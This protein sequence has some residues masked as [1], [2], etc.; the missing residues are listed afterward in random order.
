MGS[1]Q[2]TSKEP[3]DNVLHFFFNNDISLFCKVDIRCIYLF[4]QNH[5]TVYMQAK[6]IYVPAAVYYSVNN[7]NDVCLDLLLQVLFQR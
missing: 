7:K 2:L 1:N 6:G 4:F 5:V 3:A